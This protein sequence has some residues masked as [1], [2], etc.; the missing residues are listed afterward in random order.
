LIRGAAGAGA[1]AGRILVVDD[2]AGVCFALL[3]LLIERGHL[4]VAAA[5][6]REAQRLLDEEPFALVLTDV[7]MPDGSGLELLRHVVAEHP[8]VEAVLVTGVDDPYQAE[9]A[10]EL[11]ACGY[12]LKP[13]A[14]QEV[15][16]QVANALR[17]RGRKQDGSSGSAGPPAAAVAGDAAQR[18]THEAAIRRFAA[19][20]EVRNPEIGGHVE[21]V[22]DLCALLARQLGLREDRCEALR[23]ASLL[24]D[25]GKIS[26]PDRLLLK[27]G[28]LTPDER[29]QIERHT[30]IGNRLLAAARSELLE[31][32]AEIALRHHE[33]WDGLGYPDGLSGE[34]IPIEARLVAVADAFDA[35]TSDRPYRP[36]VGC[37][38]ALAVMKEE[39]E[40]QFDAA[41][42]DALVL[43]YPQ[44]IRI[45]HDAGGARRAA[46]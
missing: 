43:V 3:E 39:S 22:G 23:L 37:T 41:V 18:G 40:R 25:V 4:V 42:L 21:R 1:E 19:A 28:R 31:L 33:R 2:A 12:L 5:G 36:A 26:L 9:V 20:I 29:R 6:A 44:V 10:L 35:L 16:I 46:V 34:E 15:A 32:A 38:E 13:F 45:W 7:R 8:G 27:P 17:C 24:H 14:G 30:T 11:G